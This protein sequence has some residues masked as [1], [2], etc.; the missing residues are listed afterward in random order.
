MYLFVPGIWRGVVCGPRSMLR[1][2][3][4]GVGPTAW[5]H[6]N[7][8]ALGPSHCP[9]SVAEFGSLLLFARVKTSWDMGGWN[10]WLKLGFQ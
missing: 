5:I 4:G 10:H 3:T 8:F 1:F 6:A 9:Y 7:L 2:L